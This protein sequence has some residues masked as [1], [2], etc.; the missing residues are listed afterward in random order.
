MRKAK[1][2]QTAAADLGPPERARHGEVVPRA[3]EAAGVIG[4]RVKH[5]CRLDWYHDKASLDDRQ[6][7]AGIRFRR[8]WLLATAPPRLTGTYGPRVG[9]SVQDFHEI[10]LA[11]RR[12]TARALL[13]LGEELGAPVIAVCGFD[14]WASGR[15]PRLR[16]AL[17]LLADHYGM[18]RAA[19]M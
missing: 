6:Y 4:R 18:P 7:D 5:E 16:E 9:T 1:R 15:L 17:T 10:Q 13:A 11:A 3:T 12:R 2:R 19:P 14:E 8:D